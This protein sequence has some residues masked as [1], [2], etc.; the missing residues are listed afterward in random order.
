MKSQ[1]ANPNKPALDVM[2]IAPRTTGSH[3]HQHV[4]LRMHSRRELESRMM[5]RRRILK[6][7]KNN[8]QKIIFMDGQGRTRW[9]DC[10]RR[11][12]KPPP[13]AAAHPPNEN[14]PECRGVF[15]EGAGRWVAY[16]PGTIFFWR[17]LKPL[18]SGAIS[19][20]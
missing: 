5:T 1:L 11:Y 16:G 19:G 8:L 10:P 2:R 14:A 4:R 3:L 9:I 13:E 7:Q 6:Q 17:A 12:V 18:N 20:L 15:V